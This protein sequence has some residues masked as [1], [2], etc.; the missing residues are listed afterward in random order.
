VRG[1]PRSSKSA[2]RSS[3]PDHPVPGRSASKADVEPRSASGSAN[4]RPALPSGT[5]NPAKV[6][7]GRVTGRAAWFRSSPRF[8]PSTR[9]APV[10][11]RGDRP[12][13]RPSPCC[14]ARSLE[15]NRPGAAYLRGTGYNPLRDPLG[16]GPWASGVVR[17]PGLLGFA[18]AGRRRASACW[19]LAGSLIPRAGAS[20]RLRSPNRRLAGGRDRTG[21]GP[22]MGV[23]GGRSSLRRLAVL[24]G[25]PPRRRWI[26]PAPLDVTGSPAP[27]ACR[28]MTWCFH[29]RA[30][31]RAGGGPLLG[32]P[33]H[34]GRRL[35]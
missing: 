4:S 16:L 24:A 17:R 14:A 1:R 20:Y 18:G 31:H 22:G 7:P 35:A 23:V 29:V 28:W 8:A 19:G 11:L 26:A 2:L 21:G 10:G 25:P 27:D 15:P 5:D 3:P 6:R 34:P 30:H 13:V 9:G 33:G 12:S 32:P